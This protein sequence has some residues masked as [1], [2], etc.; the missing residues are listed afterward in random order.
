MRAIA[1]TLPFALG[2]VVSLVSA[3]EAQR[4]HYRELFEPLPLPGATERRLGSGHPGSKYWQQRA[5]Y[6]MQIKLDAETRVV[7]GAEVITYTNNAPHPLTYLWMSL[8]QNLFKS[9]SLAKGLSGRARAAQGDELGFRDLKIKSDGKDLEFQV[10]DTMA[11]IELPEPLAASGGK[12][13]IEVDWTFI[14]PKPGM[15]MGVTPHPTG[16]VFALA[17]WFPAIAVYDDVNGWNTLPYIGSG[18]FYQNF[19]DYQ[20][21][22]TVPRDHVVAATGRLTNPEDVL[23]ATQLELVEKALQS[24]ETI[25]I[26]SADEA[27]NGDGRPDGEGPV[28]WRFEAKDVRTFAWSSSKAFVWDAAGLDGV[29]VQSFYPPSALPLWEDGTQMLRSSIEGY[30]KRWFRYPYP[31]ASN[32]NALGPGGGMEYPMILFNGR[33]NS[34]KGLYFLIA[35]EIGHQWFPMI[36]NSDERRHPWMD[37]GF[38]TFINYYAMK[39]RFGTAGSQFSPAMYKMMSRMAA[40]TPMATPP[41]H[42]PNAVGINAYFKPAKMMVVLRESVIGPERF[43]RAFRD[44]ISA[45]AFK[46]PQPAD[47]F[48]LMEDAAGMDLDWFFRTWIYETHDID[49]A[50]TDA[51]IRKRRGHSLRLRFESLGTGVSVL[52]YTITFD[53]GSTQQGRVPAVSWTRSTKKTVTVPLKAGM[54]PTRVEI[55]PDRVIPETTRKNNVF[56]IDS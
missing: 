2:L 8:D 25:T 27:R 29:L 46:Q 6:R 14:V 39:D 48:R 31:T 54:T 7:Q 37:E 42:A 13:S 11:R 16:D 56:K 4:K 49:F 10:H 33:E 28:T 20:V 9:D 41:D 19:G 15:R 40:G 26:R 34:E 5:D 21:E 44:Y 43:D 22:L 51:T 30:N 1:F 24:A 50:I 47:F 55:D 45:W 38:N 23:T 35:H 3:Q 52:P 32:I 17:N 18:E 53:D 12:L 36:V